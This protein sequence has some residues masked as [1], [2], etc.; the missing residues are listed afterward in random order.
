MT[1]GQYRERELVVNLDKGLLRANKI[2]W[3]VS[4]KSKK[5]KKNLRKMHAQGTASMT[6]IL[7]AWIGV[8]DFKTSKL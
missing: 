8:F 5:K 2:Y 4:E 3:P 7:H 1:D 6:V